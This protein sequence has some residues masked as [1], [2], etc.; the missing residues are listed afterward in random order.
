MK[1]A[2]ATNRLLAAL[3]EKDRR[4]VLASCE[5][6]ELASTDILYE[7]GTRLRYVYFPTGGFISLVT[8]LDTCAGLEVAL[9]GSVAA[10]ELYDR[11]LG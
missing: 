2:V 8:P 3:P 6:V 7:A 5:K 11:I 9:V 1:R 4:R 10:N